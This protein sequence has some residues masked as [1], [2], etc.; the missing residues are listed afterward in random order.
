[1]AELDGWIRSIDT[2]IMKEYLVAYD[3]NINILITIVDNPQKGADYLKV[4]LYPT[5][6]HEVITRFAK[7]C[8][9]KII[10]KG[11][12]LVSDEYDAVENII[13]LL[14]R[15]QLLSYNIEFLQEL[16]DLTYKDQYFDLRTNECTIWGMTFERNGLYIQY[17]YFMG[18]S[19]FILVDENNVISNSDQHPIIS[20]FISIYNRHVSKCRVSWNEL[21]ERKEQERIDRER[22]KLS[23]PT[24]II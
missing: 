21:K 8:N 20:D 16:I 22:S 13:P 6:T 14:S 11:N 4:V 23:L 2:D 19:V 15:D 18:I 12:E 5:K 9:R 7:T 17:S 24:V 10:Y 1:M 3:N